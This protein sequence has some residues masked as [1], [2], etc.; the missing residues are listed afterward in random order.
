M[1][2]ILML[3]IANAMLFNFAF[4]QN[5]VSINATVGTPA[6]NSAMLDVV[7]TS[8]GMLIPRMTEAQKL[9]I[10]SPATGLLIYQTNNTS[11]FWYFNGVVWVQAIGTTG[12]TGPAGVAGATGVNGATGRTGTGTTGAT[13]P[14]GSSGANGATGPTGIMVIREQ[15]DQP[16]L[17]ELMV[18]QDQP[19]L[20]VMQEQRNLQE[21]QDQQAPEPL[22]VPMLTIY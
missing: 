3:C 10:V 7:S 19:E 13:G 15:Q 11:G 17:Q 18:L 4:S 2:K 1:K 22:V 14:T 6:D 16:D 20:M 5:G 12:T 21:L 9:A 8:K